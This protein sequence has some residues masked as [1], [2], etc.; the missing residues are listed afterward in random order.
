MSPKTL[1]Q[2]SGRARYSWA[3]ARTGHLCAGEGTATNPLQPPMSGAV[4]FTQ[5]GQTRT[6]PRAFGNDSQQYIHYLGGIMHSEP[7]VE[8]CLDAI[9][10]NTL[11]KGITC[12]TIDGSEMATDAFKDFLN[13]YYM[14]FARDAIRMF[15][16]LGFVVWRLRTITEAGAKQIVP[17]VLPLG[18]FTWNVKTAPRKQEQGLEAAARGLCNRGSDLS[19]KRMRRG[20]DPQAA[21]YDVTLSGVEC[22]YDVFEFIRPD[23]VMECVSPLATCIPLYIRMQV[24]RTCKM[25]AEEWNSAARLAVEHNEKFLLNQ[26]AD[27]GQPLNVQ[28]HNADFDTLYEDTLGDATESRAVVVRKQAESGGLPANTHLFVLPKNHSI[29]PLDTVEAPNGMPDSELE[30]QRS[31]CYAMGIPCSLVMQA[32]QVGRS[33]ASSGSANESTVQSMQMLRNTCTR[34]ATALEDLL[35]QVYELSYGDT[36]ALRSSS[37]KVEGPMKGRS[38]SKKV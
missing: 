12:T 20:D 4:M 10:S 7:I 23:L 6:P 36:A 13:R 27:E 25:R 8:R 22:D 2:A 15:F 38:A 37:L 11:I 21:F 31:I 35:G 24:S 3:H 30:F 34:V 9:I 28:S 18:S 26:M 17:E 29:R 1:K 19:K 5:Q 16:V 14:R 32:Y 33:G